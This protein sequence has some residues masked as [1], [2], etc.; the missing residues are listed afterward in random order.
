MGIC[1]RNGPFT[2]AL[3]LTVE[4]II[5]DAT[6]ELTDYLPTSVLMRFSR[7]SWITQFPL[8]FHPPFVPEENLW[9]SVCTGRMLFLSSISRPQNE[10]QSTDSFGGMASWPHLFFVQ[11]KG[12]WSFLLVLRHRYPVDKPRRTPICCRKYSVFCRS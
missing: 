9:R 3:C 10:T 4:P 1:A 11:G 8:S 12:H 7:S 6:V 5:V 2:F